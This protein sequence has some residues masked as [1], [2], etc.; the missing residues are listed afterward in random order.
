[1]IYAGQAAGL[2]REERSAGEIVREL[3]DGAEEL[4]RRRVDELTK[5]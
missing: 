2:V 1:V 4:L 3:G 5:V